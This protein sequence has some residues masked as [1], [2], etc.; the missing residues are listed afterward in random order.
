MST[1][2]RWGSHDSDYV[3]YYLFPCMWCHI[4]RYKFTSVPEEHAPSAL[5]V[6]CEPSKPAKGI[7]L[8]F[9]KLLT[10]PE[11]R[12]VCSTAVLVHHR[13][14][15]WRCIPEDGIVHGHFC[16]YLY[17][18]FH[19]TARSTFP[20]LLKCR[21]SNAWFK[22]FTFFIVTLY[23]RLLGNDSVVLIFAYLK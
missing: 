12:T 9:L 20:Q 17:I 13:P 1:S 7:R 18:T 5:R 2:V 23:I 21:R 16:Y 22:W 4:V 19:Y 10:C 6:T 15:T 8:C 3:E 14:T 11:N